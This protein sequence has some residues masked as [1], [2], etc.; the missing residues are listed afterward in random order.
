MVQ[1]ACGVAVLVA[2]AHLEGSGLHELRAR[3]TGLT[4]FERLHKLRM[5]VPCR[6]R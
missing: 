5:D 6:A 1:V 3:L 2:G 4:A